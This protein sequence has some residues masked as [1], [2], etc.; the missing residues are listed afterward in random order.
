MKKPKLYERTRWRFALIIIALVVVAAS[1]F[2]TNTVVY[3]LKLDEEKRVKL[4]FEAQ[5][6][7]FDVTP[8]EDEFCD[9]TLN[10]NI[11]ENN[12]DIPIILTD[13]YYR[14]IDVMNYKDKD[15]LKDTAYFNAE[16]AYLS[17]NQKPIVIED[18]IIKNYIFYKQSTLITSLEWFPYFQFAL[19]GV[20]VMLSYFTFS[21]NRQAEQ[22][23]VWVGMAK[24]TAHQLGTPLTSLMGWIQN[25]NMMYPEEEDLLMIAEEMNTDVELL[26]IVADRFSK[27][28]TVPKL[29]PINIYD[30]LNKHLLYVQ[31]RASRKISFDFPDPAAQAPLMVNINPLLFDWVVENLLKNALDA[32]EGKGQIEARVTDGEYFVHIDISDTG[33]G[34]PK[35]SFKSVFQPGYSTKK[36]GW[37]LGLSLCKRIVEKYH[38]GKIFVLKSTEGK[39][40]TFRIQLPQIKQPIQ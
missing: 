23:R 31:Q 5:Q 22:E 11:M 26:R 36:R 12:S 30:N 21:F 37:G 19:L 38:N 1:V 20:L 8:E 4:W 3:Q 10:L 29:G 27:I 18:A 25:I 34:I 40:T 13:E 28:G 16:I 32:S 24:E 17:K 35:R 33:K 9:F 15:V 6:A 14:I 39:G 2:Y 7:M